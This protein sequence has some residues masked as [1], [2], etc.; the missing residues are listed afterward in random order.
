MSI[1]WVKLVQRSVCDDLINN[2]KKNVSG[3]C[4]RS[5]AD[6]VFLGIWSSVQLFTAVK[7]RLKIKILKLFL[8]SKFCLTD[9]PKF[10]SK[11]S[12]SE[13][14]SPRSSRLFKE[15]PK[16]NPLS[17]EEN[18]LQNLGVSSGCLDTLICK[19]Q[20]YSNFSFEKSTSSHYKPVAEILGSGTCK[21][22][23]EPRLNHSDFFI[24]DFAGSDNVLPNSW[25]LE[26]G[27]SNILDEYA[28]DESDLSSDENVPEIMDNNGVKV[29]AGLEDEAFP[30]PDFLPPPFNK[31]DLQG[32]SELEGDEWKRGLPL[33]TEDAA[34]QLITRLLQMERLKVMTIQ[35]ERS[36]ACRTRPSTVTYIRPISGK[37]FCKLKQPRQQ[38]PRCFQPIGPCAEKI[39]LDGISSYYKHPHSDSKFSCQLCDYKSFLRGAVAEGQLTRLPGTAYNTCQY[40]RNRTVLNTKQ[41]VLHGPPSSSTSLCRSPV[42]DKIKPIRPVPPGTAECS[43]SLCDRERRMYRMASI[44]KKISYGSDSTAA[45]KSFPLQGFN[46]L[47]DPPGHKNK[48]PQTAKK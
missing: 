41:L 48:R 8:Q 25:N 47:S 3:P 4:H 10:Y 19:P 40:S 5:A 15:Q 35:R 6:R 22:K 23:K 39:N 42:T 11:I 36:R 1:T 13:Q 2:N 34:E 44:K 20:H 26:A 21:N 33:K 28:A 16:G 37:N 24:Q 12:L 38:D 27:D 43:G 7:L 45:T 46:A 14:D 30:Y 18:K 17:A 32:L 31:L 29:S 9:R